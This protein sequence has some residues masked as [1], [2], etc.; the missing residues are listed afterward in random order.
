MII[1]PLN[2]VLFGAVFLFAC[3]KDEPTAPDKTTPPPVVVITPGEIPS[4]ATVKSWIVDKNATNETAAMFYNLKKIS[5]TSILFGHQ[6]ATKRGVTNSTTQWENAQQ[7]SGISKESSDVKDVTGSYPAVY[8]HDFLHIANF[9]TGA[10]FDYEKKIAKELTIEA[11]N[12]GGVN[13]Y[14]WHYNNPVSKGSFYWKDSQVAAVPRILPGGDTHEVYKNSLKQVADF[15]KTLIGADGKLVPVIFRP[16]HEF[17]GDWF[18]WGKAHCTPEQYK[19]LYQFTVSYL[20]DEMGVRN[21]LYAWSPDKNFTTEAQYLERYPGDDF[22]DLVGSDNYG[23][24]SGSSITVASQKLKIV[25]D[26]AVK[27]NKLAALTETGLATISKTDWYTQTLLKA[28]QNTKL[29]LAF[30]MVWANTKTAYYTPYKGHAA[31]NDFISFKNNPYVI[32]GSEMPAVYKMPT[33]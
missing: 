4:L 30:A 13:T 3:K 11:Y 10:W 31:E 7:F 25:S 5:K 24:L 9:S 22:V 17:D 2:L 16:F 21:F 1:K 19:Q 8:G 15:A 20:R 29:E 23:D 12:R 33:K 14:A 27:K 26:Y 18:W 28:L 6:D 32:F